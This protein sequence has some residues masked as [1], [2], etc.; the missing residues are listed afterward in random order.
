M[1]LQIIEQFRCRKLVTGITMI[2]Y[3]NERRVTQAKNHLISTEQ[4]I[5]EIAQFLVFCTAAY[6]S[7]IF[8][9]SE[10]ISPSEY[11]KL[12]LFYCYNFAA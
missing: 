12:H 6:F 7:E 9:K 11:R 3:R 2:E 1:L 8:V 10:K 4:S 5:N